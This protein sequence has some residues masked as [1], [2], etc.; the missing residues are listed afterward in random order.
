MALYPDISTKLPRVELEEDEREYQTVTDKPKA[1]FSDLANAALHNAGINAD[2][3]VQGAQ[4]QAAVDVEW[5]GPVLVEA[6]AD[7]IV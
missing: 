2:N 1:N 4:A 5:Q 3:A 6:N 7:K